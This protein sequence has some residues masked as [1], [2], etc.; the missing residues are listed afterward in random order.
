MRKVTLL[1]A[2]MFAAAF[3][4]TSNIATSTS[5][6]AQ[7]ADPNANAHKLMRDAWNPYGATAKPAEAPKAA[8]KGGKKKK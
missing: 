5:A 3:F 2:A 8:K 6:Q 1:A 7:A 4:T